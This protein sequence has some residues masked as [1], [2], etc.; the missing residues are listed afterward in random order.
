MQL[1]DFCKGWGKK[2]VD[3]LSSLKMCPGSVVEPCPPA[4]RCRVILEKCD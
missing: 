2:L 3:L 4:V 1:R